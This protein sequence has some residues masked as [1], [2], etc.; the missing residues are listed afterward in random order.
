ME[1][2]EQRNLP[3]MI[4]TVTKEALKPV[5]MEPQAPGLIG[6]P[7]FCI[8]GG[9]GQNIIIITPG[10][11]GNEFNKTIGGYHSYPGVH[12]YHVV[13]G[14]GLIVMQR[15]DEA[16]EPKE[17][18]VS[19]IRGGMNVEIPAGY[20]HCLVNVGKNYLVVIEG[21]A[22]ATANMDTGPVLKRHGLAYYLV[23]KKGD[24]AFEANLNYHLHPQI[25]TE[26]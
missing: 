7:Y 25:S 26:Q 17:V 2:W 20:G 14:T 22:A 18:R 15:N 12:T 16:G 24:V 23:D 9:P 8:E 1:W 19:S 13:F 10:R 11:N 6:E 4:K 3:Y 5:L 21:S